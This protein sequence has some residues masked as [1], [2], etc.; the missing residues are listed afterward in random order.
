MPTLSK[1]VLLMLTTLLPASLSAQTDGTCVPVSER[2]GR[3]LGCFVTARE[4][5]GALPVDPPLYWHVDTYATV[6]AAN[7]AKGPRGTVVESLGRIW[8]FSIA[9]ADYRPA[10]GTRVARIGP[11][12][13]VAAARFAAVYM[14]GVFQP[15]MT[16]LV[17]RHPGAEAWY[18]VEGSQC[19]ETPKGR[20]D[21][22]AGDPGVLVPGGLPMMLTGTGTGTRRSVVLILQDAALPRSTEAHD[23]TPKGLCSPE[24]PGAAQWF[25]RPAKIASVAAPVIMDS[26]GLFQARF[27]R[28]GEDIFVAGQPTQRGLREMRD[29]GVTTVVNLRTPEEMTRNVD[30]DEPALVAQLGMRYVYLP[31]RGNAEFPYTPET[32]TKFAEAVSTA[33][34]KVLLHCTVAWRASHLWA[35]YLIDRGI[36]VDSAL[37]NARAINLM[38]DHRMGSNGRQPVED[39]LNRSLPTL[40]HAHR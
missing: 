26:T 5:L 24:S 35:A 19:L 30:F 8:L 11:L 37:A 29:Q 12:P 32:L 33:N 23:W 21:Q 36:P 38:D 10:G 1:P 9:P 18:T 27:A 25:T 13:L 39:F 34:G 4:E 2:G 15:G 7:T 17:H 31:V 20:I 14:E 16:S 3:V 6:A 28:V 40:G 22:R